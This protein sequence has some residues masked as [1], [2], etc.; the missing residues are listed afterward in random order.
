[1][2]REINILDND[3]RDI[4]SDITSLSCDISSLNTAINNINRLKDKCPL[5]K[6]NIIE[7]TKTILVHK[8]IKSKEDLKFERQQL[9]KN[10][11]E[12]KIVLEKKEEELKWKKEDTKGYE[13]LFSINEQIEKLNSTQNPYVEILEEYMQE[14]SE[15][16]EKFKEVFKELLELKNLQKYYEFWDEG[17][18]NKGI[19]S[20]IL[21]FIISEFSAR[22]NKYLQ[23]LTDKNISV[24]LDTQKEKKTGGF[25]ERFTIII[26]DD[27]GERPYNAWSGGKR[28]EFQ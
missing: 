21:D 23:N 17:F 25:S 19:K 8:F 14:G 9:G 5:C 2:D 4:Q 18:S 28:K 24:I 22:A 3:L 11:N 6:Q 10:Y 1:M 12:Y 13:I 20:Y 26:K 27:I 16:E 7:D 15:V